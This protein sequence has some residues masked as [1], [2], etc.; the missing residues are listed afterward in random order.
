MKTTIKL[1]AILGIAGL[2]ILFNTTCQA[3]DAVQATSKPKDGAENRREFLTWSPGEQGI[4]TFR[5]D[6]PDK[7]YAGPVEFRIKAIE[8]VKDGFTFK[9][10]SYFASCAYK[11]VKVSSKPNGLKPG[12]PDLTSRGLESK[13]FHIDQLPKMTVAEQELRLPAVI[14]DVKNEGAAFTAVFS[15]AEEDVTCTVERTEYQ[16]TFSP[17]LPPDVRSLHYG[18]HFRQTIDFF[19][20]KSDKPTPVV[21]LIHGGGWGG[22]C[23]TGVGG[24]TSAEP[25][26]KQGISVARINYRFCGMD[27]LTP[28]VAA[29]LLDAAR[30]VQFLRFKA[31]EL[32]IDKSRFAAAGV[33]AGGYSALWLAFHKDLANPDSSDSV[34]RQS[35]RL[36]CAGGQDTP[37]TLDPQQ[38]QDWIPVN[39]G[40]GC[41]EA[42][43]HWGAPYQK[44]LDR[45]DEYLAKGYIQEFSPWWLVARDSPPVCLSF[46]LPMPKPGEKDPEQIHSPLWGLHLQERTKE[47]GVECHLTSA[48]MKDSD[49][50]YPGYYEFICKKL[51]EE[52]HK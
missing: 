14:S 17:S 11:A 48:G 23:K 37:T 3:V 25:F 18:P 24:S 34:A 43:A 41:F 32:N 36:L 52:P 30:A 35:T 10:E 46:G 15:F 19:K 45:R 33:S 29:P 5:D 31:A 51:K 27:N 44:F 12:K 42:K 28:P 7:I 2:A 26:L 21:V 50:E 9:P 40:Y 22:G 1:L 39:W 49:P 47:I 6:W 13:D 38:I 8:S 20:A 16:I 4:Q